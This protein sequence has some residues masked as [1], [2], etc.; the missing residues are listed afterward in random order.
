MKRFLG[1]YAASVLPALIAGLLLMLMPGFAFAATD[2]VVEPTV[3]K[4]AIDMLLG[5]QSVALFSII[6]LGLWFGRWTVAGLNL[7]SSGVI[8]VALLFGHLHYGIPVG[9]GTFGLV[10]FIYCVGISAGPTFFTILSRQGANFAK[11]SFIV[12]GFAALCAYAI[13]EFIGIPQSLVFGLFA[14][15]LTSTP[16][17][18]AA[19]DVSSGD[20]SL[21][22][23]GYGIAY[24]FGVVGVVLFVQLLPRL[25]R[26]SLDDRAEGE[27]GKKLEQQIVRA[28]V[29][30][31]N[32]A[33]FGRQIAGSE[34]LP[35][36]SCQIS[37]VMRDEHLVPLAAEDVFAEG[38]ILF[39][40]GDKAGT[41]LFVDFIGERVEKEIAMD[42]VR[43]RMNVVLTAEEFVGKSI[44]DLGLF[45]R[46]G[47]VI[48][49][50]ERGEAAFVPRADTVLERADK[51]LVVGDP[52]L[53]NRFSAAVGHRARALHETDL[54][55]LSVGI[56]AGII[57]GMMPFAL[58]G[59]K[60]FTLGL[61]GGP[62]F[63]A[64]IL[65]H[66]GRI[67]PFTARIPLAAQHFMRELG[68][69]LFLADAGVKAGGTFMEIVSQ[70]GLQLFVLGAAVTTM[71]MIIGYIAGRYM[72]LSL[73]ECLGGLCGAM[74][75]TPALG[76]L[77]AK[78]ES[79]VPV[80]S[81]AAAYPVALVL[82]I[83][84]VQ[85]LFYLS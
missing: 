17:L 21:V 64:L 11:L 63:V 16:A 67:G 48:T 20:V 35:G 73:P 29:K 51:M 23:V 70:Y 75:S 2:S 78:T 62:L 71:P 46:F 69:I 42:V 65:G 55:S 22:S 4:S 85:I 45:S 5:N 13:S 83:V 3:Q 44:R 76:T 77:T 59:T 15:A 9:V 84:F 80:V 12:V 54:I 50:V 57:L 36:V 53:L 27:K 10:L 7:G 14:G 56:L 8:F 41:D 72:G 79:D 47:V 39:L 40:V 31:H 24:P 26:Q 58:P 66:F 30:V 82:M 74:T 43:E 28:L 81:Y 33:L 49:R 60:G 25:L 52:A 19:L 61:T 6:A 37:R 68:L 1:D 18:A 38:Q 32:K 34:I